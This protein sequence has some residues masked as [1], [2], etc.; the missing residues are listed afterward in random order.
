[1]RGELVD[2]LTSRFD[3]LAGSRMLGL[4]ARPRLA[5]IA[6]IQ[7]TRDRAKRLLRRLQLAIGDV[8]QAVDRRRDPLFEL[9][10][11]L[12]LLASKTERG[13]R[14]RRDVVLEVVEVSAERLRRFGL[15]V[16]E[17]AEQMEIVN[18]RKGAR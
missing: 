7:S 6:A 11:L 17:I 14:A 12:E 8:E 16:G 3:Q 4:G 10:F 18:A 2:V 5:R 15:R 13:A 1:E 9:Q